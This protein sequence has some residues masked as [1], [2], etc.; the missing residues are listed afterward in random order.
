MSFLVIP[1]YLSTEDISEIDGPS[2]FGNSYLRI[3]EVK[4]IIYPDDPRS[5]SKRIIEYNI[6]VQH[7]GDSGPATP[8]MYNNCALSNLFGG[9]ADKFRYTLRQATSLPQTDTGL[10]IGSKVLLLCINGDQTKSIIL[11]GIREPTSTERDDSSDGHNLF[12]EFNGLKFQINDDGEATLVFRGKTNA[13]GTLADSADVDAEGT[14]VNFNKDGNLEAATPDL[15]QFVRLNHKDKKIEVLA[16]T[17][18][19]VEVNGK[20]VFKAGSEIQI[21]GGSTATLAVPGNVSVSSAGVKVG[22]ATDAWVKG[23]TYRNAE[24]LMN[25]QMA[26]VFKSLSESLQKAGEQLALGNS[27]GAGA[28]LVASGPMLATLAN[29]IQQFEDMSSS[30]LSTK[31]ST[32]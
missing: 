31:N 8:T 20:L 19:N 1:S 27:P 12:F 29:L 18:W 26:S 6:R 17:E 10:G 21:N 13:D 2:L 4:E 32:D 22:A 7:Q 9:V 23:T 15:Q 5:L 28:L 25:T 30:Y 24:S 3:G 11:S 16:D 14:S